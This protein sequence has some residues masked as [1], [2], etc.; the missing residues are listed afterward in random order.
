MALPLLEQLRTMLD[1]L[2]FWVVM[3]TCVCACMRDCFLK[4]CEHDTL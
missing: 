2:C 1:A 3:Q 4:V